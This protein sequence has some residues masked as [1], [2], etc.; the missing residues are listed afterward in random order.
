MSVRRALTAG[1]GRGVD[2]EANLD[3]GW[4]GV[5]FLIDMLEPDRDPDGA[6]VDG[7]E[8]RADPG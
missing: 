5:T 2:D 8:L 7:R 6:G 3:E 4:P 1:G